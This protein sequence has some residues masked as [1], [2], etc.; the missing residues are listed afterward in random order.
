MIYLKKGQKLFSNEGMVVADPTGYYEDGSVVLCA[1]FHSPNEPVCS[2]EAKYIAYGDQVYNMTSEEDLIK[3]IEK[4]DPNT[5]IGKTAKDVNLDK[6]IEEIQTVDNP[7]PELVP[8]KAFVETEQVT[9][10]PE[11]PVVEPTVE[12]PIVEPTVESVVT[13]DRT[14]EIIPIIETPV[15]V[16]TT[17]PP[18]LEEIV[19]INIEASTTT[20]DIL[21]KIE[22]ATTTVSD[23][24]AAAKKRL[25]KRNK[26]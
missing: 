5:L 2:Y 19:P 11:V 3:E 25:V 12:A 13:Q 10:Q 24:V 15:E 18:V 20:S 8:D 26:A 21:E 7:T 4:I 22:E 16:S 23:I 6:L 1:M 14:P 17:T 9:G